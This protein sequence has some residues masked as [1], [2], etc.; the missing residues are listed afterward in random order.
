MCNNCVDQSQLQE[1]IQYLSGRNVNTN[2]VELHPGCTMTC[3][4]CRPIERKDIEQALRHCESDLMGRKAVFWTIWGIVAALI[5]V[6]C[7]GWSV[8]G[9]ICVVMALTIP[10]WKHYT[11]DQERLVEKE[12]TVQRFQELYGQLVESGNSYDIRNSEE[13]KELYWFVREW[14]TKYLLDLKSR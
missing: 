5:V 1:D 11:W 13:Y 14:F 4:F 12:L 3:H 6:L 8:A 9:G 7:A 10:C 2:G